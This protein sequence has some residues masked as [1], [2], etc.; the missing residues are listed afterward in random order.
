[1]LIAEAQWAI[2]DTYRLVGNWIK[3]AE[4]SE[5]AAEAWRQ[6]VRPWGAREH[7]ASASAEQDM[8]G[9]DDDA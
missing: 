6:V 1:M 8:K 7:A 5:K 3:A 9:T 4:H 2:S